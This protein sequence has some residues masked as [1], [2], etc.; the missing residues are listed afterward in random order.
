V[1]SLALTISGF[2]CAETK[3]FAKNEERA[4]LKWS[5]KPYLKP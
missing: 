2:C 4:P 1:K 5:G 3:L